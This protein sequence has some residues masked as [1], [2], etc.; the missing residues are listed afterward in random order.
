MR[1]IWKY[2]LEVTD[3]QSVSMPRNAEILHVA[4]Q[5]GVACLWAEVTPDTPEEDRSILIV[6]T[7]HPIPIGDRRYIGTFQL[8]GGALVFHAYEFKN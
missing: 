1:T 2:Q 8:S 7:G 5:H 3:Q 6:G 4:A